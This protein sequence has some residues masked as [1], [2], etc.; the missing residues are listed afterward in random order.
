VSWHSCQQAV[1]SFG[2]APPETIDLDESSQSVTLDWERD[3]MDGE[4]L[5]GPGG[6]VLRGEA[7]R[8]FYEDCLTQLEKVC[9]RE[10]GTWQPGDIRA[11]KMMWRRIKEMHDNLGSHATVCLRKGLREKIGSGGLAMCSGY[12]CSDIAFTGVRLCQV[13][14][15][16]YWDIKVTIN[17]VCAAESQDARIKWLLAN[18]DAAIVVR[19]VEELLKSSVQDIRSG[20]RKFAPCWTYGIFG[21]PCLSRSKC[22]ANRAEFLHCV[23]NGVGKTGEGFVPL[24]ELCKINQGIEDILLENVTD[25]AQAADEEVSDAD[26]I[27]EVLK[28]TGFT[29]D[30]H[31]YGARAYGSLPERQRLW[32]RGKKGLGREAELVQEHR[33]ILSMQRAPLDPKIFFGASWEA[34]SEY[35][36][37]WDELPSENKTKL[38]RVNA[39]YH[40]DHIDLFKTHSLDYPPNYE[41]WH[42]GPKFANL[43]NRIAFGVMDQRIKEMVLSF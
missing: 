31:E 14:W 41:A 34:F 18:S 2:N 28:D 22:F 7:L 13:Y 24:A 19:N 5:E 42:D 23:Q 32:W 12:S 4:E 9:D 26:F 33:M 36:E 38:L 10:L 1:G 39:A 29:A 16:M 21:F 15:Q 27:L 20:E 25:L 6:Q 43:C 11:F 40:D 35:A 17:L 37:F 3:D 8:I 30:F